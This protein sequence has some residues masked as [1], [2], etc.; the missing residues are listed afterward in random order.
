MNKFTGVITAL[1]TPFKKGEVDLASYKKLLASQ[2]EQ[3]V[4]GFVINGTTGESP[5]L[6]DSEV[7]ELFDC[8]R[9]ACKGEDVSLIVGTGSNSTDK[10]CALTQK[11]EKWGADAALSVVPYYNKPPQRGLV[12][13]FKLIADSTS[14]PI[15]LYNVPSRTIASLTVESIAELSKVRNIVG[16]KEASGDM[17]FLKQIRAKVSADFLLLSGDDA[18]CVEF[19]AL[20]GHGVISVSS[21]IIGREMVEILRSNPKNEQAKYREQYADFM[22]WLYC[23]ANPI[24][25]KAALH[26]MGIFASGE[27]RLPLTE[28][29]R[30][31]HKE[32]KECLK[33][34]GKI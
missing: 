33:N 16:I 2:L 22:K 29:D 3:G 21:H 12:Q 13:H 23:E 34:L 15:I 18:S 32:F 24:P 27:L 26:W 25:L 7:K 1:A 10:A 8:A 30:A 5:T 6:T 14:L 20:G 11:V 28:L 9:T 17:N 19:C 31:F 4:R